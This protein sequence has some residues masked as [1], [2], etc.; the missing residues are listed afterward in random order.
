MTPM[1]LNELSKGKVC[2]S[3]LRHCLD[4]RKWKDNVVEGVREEELLKTI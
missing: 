4:K 3:I 2:E 1:P